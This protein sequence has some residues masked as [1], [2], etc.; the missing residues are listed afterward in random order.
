MA[1]VVLRCA[2][3]LENFH[4][5][6]LRRDP[7]TNMLTGLVSDRLRALHADLEAERALVAR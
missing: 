3:R 5:P 4:P 6:R 1:G 2:R 7:E